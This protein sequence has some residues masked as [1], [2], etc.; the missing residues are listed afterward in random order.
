MTNFGFDVESVGTR[1]RP[2]LPPGPDLT[3]ERVAQFWM[4][5]PLEFFGWCAARY[6]DA[7]TIELGSL[8]TSVVFG[9]PEAVRQ[10]FQ[11]RPET[12]EVRPFNDYYKSVMGDKAL[13]LTDGPDHRRMR[14]V[15]TPALHG[16]LAEAHGEAARR[17]AR[18]AVAGWPA[19][20]LFSPRP[21]LHLMSLKVVLGIVFGHADVLADE[22][23]RVFS[24]E[25]YQELG[26]WS[27][28]TRF[29]HLQPRLRGRIAAEIRR[30]R[31]AP[32]G[33]GGG[34]L[35]DALV[36]ARDD[37]GRFLEDDWIQ[38]NIFTMIV[39][40]ADP[41]ALAVAWSL[42]WTHEDPEVLARLRRELAG[43]G[44]DP[45]PAQVDRLPYLTAVCQETLRMY[46][47]PTTPSGRKLVAPA[48]ICGRRYEPGVTLLTGTHLVHR[49]AD[50]YP[51]PDR[52]RPERF[53]ERSYAPHEYF[54]FGGGARTCVG[55]SLAPVEMRLALAEILTR[56]ELT[57]AHGG[58]VVPVRHGTLLAPSD[59]MRF[60][61]AG[62]P[63]SMAK[64]RTL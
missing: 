35:F 21:S 59:A 42:Y 8:G 30:R 15:L 27:A 6:G 20:R 10:V 23:A 13:F 61:L 2:G 37:A 22:I 52:F 46:P 32:G 45:A 11:L 19:G 29:A 64:A 9:H 56:C 34:T 18:E 25:I 57:P 60:T 47:I 51:E 63:D 62:P 17:L 41:T 38:D 48:E 50:L 54:P 14:R 49:R 43:L 12:Y 5:R 28:W 31:E 39:A 3:A 55:A 44:P 40:G 7:Y 16:R 33:E 4:G 26:S 36:R 1:E 24:E 53:L 58:P